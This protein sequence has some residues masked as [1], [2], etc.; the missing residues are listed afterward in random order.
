MLYRNSSFISF[1]T[2]FKNYSFFVTIPTFLSHKTIRHN[3]FSTAGLL[4]HNS[5]DMETVNE[6]NVITEGNAS[7]LFPKG[8]KVFYN[9]VQQFNR[10]VSIAA[11]KT[12]SEIYSEEK[13]RKANRKLQQDSRNKCIIMIFF[14]NLFIFTLFVCS[15]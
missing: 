2:F 10:D 5:L 11:I 13:E 15:H 7:I 4:N 8:N 6:F 3:Y 9:N 1:H 12:W 14:F